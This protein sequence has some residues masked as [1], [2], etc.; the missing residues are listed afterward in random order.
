MGGGVIDETDARLRGSVETECY[1]AEHICTFHICLSVNTIST[2][3]ATP[4]YA[5]HSR[6]SKER[7]PRSKTEI[8]VLIGITGHGPT[9]HEGG[10]P[11]EGGWTPRA[12]LGSGRDEKYSLDHQAIKPSHP[13][14]RM[15]RCLFW[16]LLTCA[17][18]R[19]STDA[20]SHSLNPLNVHKRSSFLAD[21]LLR[22]EWRP[23]S[24]ELS[25]RTE[26]LAATHYKM[27]WVVP[28]K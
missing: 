15:T 13:P 4:R 27:G 21:E 16:I 23:L 12:S 19:S 17:V 22:G 8:G 28:V 3:R 24:S 11:R 14:L 25:E 1:Q 10:P 7:S 20:T 9:P 26:W 5:Y 6:S 2:Y 18:C